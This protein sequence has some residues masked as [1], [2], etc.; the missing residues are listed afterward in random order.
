MA[1]LTEDDVRRIIDEKLADPLSFP[2]EFKSWVPSWT[3]AQGIQLPISQV[4]G[5]YVVASTVSGL[6]PG[7]HGRTGVI[8]GGVTPY[9]FL[10]VTYDQVYGKWVSDPLLVCIRATNSG[11]DF[12]TTSTTS[13]S[14]PDQVSAIFPCRVWETAGLTSQFRMYANLYTT[15]LNTAT[16]T[17]QILSGDDGA[18]ALSVTGSNW[19]VTTTNTSGTY[20][21]TSWFAPFNLAKDFLSA[22]M[23]LKTSAGTSFVNHASMIFRWV[24]A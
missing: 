1:L 12:A 19:T 5:T 3:E 16:V 4:I 9:D 18:T 11:P 13:K 2:K 15:A 22:E 8:R 7:V 20:K 21:S 10:K 14:I 17:A 23:L 6:G 24:S